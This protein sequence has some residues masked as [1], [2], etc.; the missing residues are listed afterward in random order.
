MKINVILIGGNG[1][2]N[3]KKAIE[4]NTNFARASCFFVQSLPS[5]HDYDIKIPNFMFYKG[6]A[7][8]M[9]KFGS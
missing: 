8:K 2:E 7:Q 5:L 1:N 4:Q 9:R 3:V 6:R